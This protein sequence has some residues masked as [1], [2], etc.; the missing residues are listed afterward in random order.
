[1][2]AAIGSSSSLRLGEGQPPNKF[3]I[4]ARF[5][6][7]IGRTTKSLDIAVFEFNNPMVENAMVEAQ[8]RGVKVR[9]VT[10]KLGYEEE[11]NRF[12]ALE[13]AGLPIVVRPDSGLMHNKFAILD[14]AEVWTGSWNYT[15]GAIYRNNENA[16]SLEG[17]DI[18]A[19]YQNVF[20]QMFEAN[21]FGRKRPASGLVVPLSHGILAM[22]S[23]EDPIAKE[24]LKRLSSTR[25]SVAFLAFAI[26]HPEVIDSLLARSQTLPVR[27]IIERKLAQNP[28]TRKLIFGNGSK[29]QLRLGVS[30]GNLHHD[31]MVIDDELVITGSTNFSR[32]AFESNDENIV[33]IPDAQL[34]AKYMAEFSRFWMFS[35][36]AGSTRRAGRFSPIQSPFIAAL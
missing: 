15:D 25:K 36:F 2:R 1:M 19:H 13:K 7:A 32:A 21:Q 35:P 33:F 30:P 17:Q 20:N 6:D 5:A 10:G 18:A 3:G 11:N 4:D 27:G 29:I 12:P 26:T 16:L 9:V 23:P 34:A 31:V 22:F 28:G 14:G 24:L 8:R